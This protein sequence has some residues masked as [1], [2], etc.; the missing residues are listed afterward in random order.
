[1][2]Q[3]QWWDDWQLRVVVLASLTAQYFLVLFAGIRKFHIPPWLRVS[4]RLAHIGSDALAIFALA[5]LFSRQKNGPRCSYV[6]G[7]RELELLWAPIVLMHLGGQVVTTT[8]KI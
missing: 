5:T 8:Y 1:M 2:A 4:F 7:S 3:V 6:R